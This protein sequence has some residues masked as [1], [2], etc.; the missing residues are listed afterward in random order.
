MK[1]HD[2]FIT[3]EN[4]FIQMK[5]YIIPI[6]VAI[7]VFVGCKK[8]AEYTYNSEDNV[9]LDYPNEDALTYS[10]SYKPSVD[11]D[12][13]WIPVK[14]SGNRVNKDRK[15]V[16]S[17]IDPSTSAVRDFHYEKLKDSY[18]M[19]KDSG[20][21]RVPIILKNIDTGLAK[22]SVSLTLRVIGGEDFKGDLPSGKR[23]KTVTFSNRLEQPAWW[24][25]W[26]QLRAYGRVKH[27]LFIIVNGTIDLVDPTKP[28]AYYDIPRTLYYI[29]NMRLFVTYP[30]DWVKQN[31][32][33][34]YEVKLR[35]DGTGD[36][37]FYNVNAPA[38]KF[39]LKFFPTANEYVFIDESGNQI[40][41]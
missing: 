13:V 10:F 9:Y 14:I 19:P 30:L 37:D 34:G 25:Y 7:A 39:H 38:K 11:K 33:R 28:N 41:M 5:K 18:I 31:P 40:K 22:K 1:N 4:K 32:I 20:M 21:V 12:T 8:D 24:K 27:E 35:T 2:S 6:I 16:M 3:I 15:F 36:Y 26:G 17:V 23:T 29:E